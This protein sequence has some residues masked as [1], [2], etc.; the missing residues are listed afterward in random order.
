M[1]TLL[2]IT[3]L[4]AI[5]FCGW[6]AVRIVQGVGFKQDCGGYLRRASNANTVELAVR[7]LSRALEYMERNN[8][9][10]GY[11]SVLWRTPDEDVGYWHDNI[12]ASL[13][14]L[15]AIKPDAGQLERSNV[16]MKLRETLIDRGDKGDGLTVPD[17]ISAFPA[18]TA[19]FIWG[20]L[21]AL[22]AVGCVALAM[23]DNF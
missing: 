8:L 18:N 19:L 15:K 11:T 21:S 6:A 22:V 10:T 13:D 23:K 12:R 2:V 17:G 7:E 3:T 20:W 9:T 14:E 1:K 4:A 16:L 5:S